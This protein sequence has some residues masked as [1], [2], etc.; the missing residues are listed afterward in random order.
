MQAFLGLYDRPDIV[1]AIL[2][3]YKRLDISQCSLCG[4]G[5]INFISGTNI[6]SKDTGMAYDL[7][8]IV[9]KFCPLCG[10][11]L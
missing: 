10:K 4:R 5:K 8:K 11:S 2:N 9:P 6:I 3:Q 7:G 1:E